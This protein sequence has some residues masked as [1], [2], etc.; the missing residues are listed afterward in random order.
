MKQKSSLK[1][2][3][4]LS[5]YHFF[6]CYVINFLRAS[7]KGKISTEQYNLILDFFVINFDFI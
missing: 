3:V 2:L 1:D 7:A 5:T 4:L 6:V